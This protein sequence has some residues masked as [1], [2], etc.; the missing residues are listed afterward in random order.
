VR[1]LWSPRWV[2]RHA[3]MVVLVAAFLALGWWQIGRAQGGNAL[4]YGY[5]VEW[6]LFALFVIAVWARE[7]RAELHPDRPEP[8][9]SGES[10][11]GVTPGRRDGTARRRPVVVPY[12]SP[13]ADAGEDPELAAYNDYLA[14]LAAHPD[15]RPSE[16]H[17]QPQAYRQPQADRQ[18]QGE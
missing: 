17:R 6:P 14:W 18:P 10:G 7:V 5:A 13:R 12:R 15:R 11:Q 16:Y 4:S 8:A 3:A 1:R 2:V 9:G